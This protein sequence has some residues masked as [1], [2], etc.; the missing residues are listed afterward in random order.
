M[1]DHQEN[2]APNYKRLSIAL[3]VV[4]ELL[5]GLLETAA[6]ERVSWVLVCH[7]G[8]VAQYISNTDRKDGVEL[9]EDTLSRW[10]KGKADIPA[11]YNP[12]I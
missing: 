6:G 7:T 10:N 11:H 9:L 2:A 4:A 1:S 3:P 5:D 12:D 8:K